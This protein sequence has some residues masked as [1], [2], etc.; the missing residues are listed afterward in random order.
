[1]PSEKK[2]VIAE[3]LTEEKLKESVAS[4]RALQKKR[5]GQ[6]HLFR[7]PITTLYYFVLVSLS[8]LFKFFRLL[9][10]Y[11]TTTGLVLATA[12]ISCTVY[13]VPGS[14]Q[15]QVQQFEKEVLWALWWVVLGILSSVGLGTGLHTFVLYLG[16]HI[17]RVTLFATECGTLDFDEHGEREFL[18]PDETTAQFI[19]TWGLLRK[20]QWEAFLWGLGTAIGEL[21]PYF[22]ARAARAAN[23]TLAEIEELTAEDNSSKI[24][25]YVAHVRRKLLALVDRLGF[26][27]ILLFASI[28]NPLFD[29]AG[30]TSGYLGVPFWRFFGATAIGKAIFKVHMQVLFVITMFHVEN[31]K[32][33]VAF[34]ERMIP[35]IHGRL[36]EIFEKEK[37]KFHQSSGRTSL[38]P[39]KGLLGRLWDLFLI[40]MIGYFV[41]SII[42]SVVQGYLHK[43]DEEEVRNFIDKY[44]ET[45]ESRKVK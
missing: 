42:N 32:T 35:P 18:C 33:V 11:K 4:I 23:E 38:P 20:V 8:N 45:G 3:P 30:L 27:G 29:L 21:P 10:F 2:P 36:H 43:R 28:P 39:S 9:P 37:A 15:S 16:P 25:K 31:L 24:M 44:T 34:L 12:L 5:R 19:S 1:M 7:S 22:V 13:F 26:F 14:H 41:I 40:F 17:A 6:I